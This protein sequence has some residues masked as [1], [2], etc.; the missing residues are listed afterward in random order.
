M[1]YCDDQQKR[2]QTNNNGILPTFLIFVF[3]AAV[4]VIYDVCCEKI[5]KSC[6][7]NSIKGLKK[8]PYNLFRLLCEAI[9][10]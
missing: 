2:K 8:K 10:G 3:L 9:S 5:L 1:M 7:N 4:L 6:E